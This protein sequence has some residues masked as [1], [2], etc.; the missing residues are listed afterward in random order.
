MK[1]N[2]WL[3][4]IR[5]FFKKRRTGAKRD[6]SQLEAK[7]RPEDSL[8]TDPDAATRYTNVIGSVSS[9]GINRIV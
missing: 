4:R 1:R 9:D 8:L 7:H 6:W 5:D 2:T 3:K